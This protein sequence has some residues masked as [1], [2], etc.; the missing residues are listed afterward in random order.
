MILGSGLDIIDLKRIEAAMHRH[1][2]A[3][4]YKVYAGTEI[5]YCESRKNSAQHYA[6]AHAIVQ[7]DGT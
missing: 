6:A 1:G 2:Q 7:G 5:S 4:L 3:F